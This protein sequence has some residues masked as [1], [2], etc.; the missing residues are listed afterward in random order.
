MQTLKQRATHNARVS[1]MATTSALLIGTANPILRE[2][3][4]L[5]LA[6]SGERQSQ[7]GKG[8]IYNK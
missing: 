1:L 4:F 7:C 5:D 2:Q 3:Q 6:A 8:T